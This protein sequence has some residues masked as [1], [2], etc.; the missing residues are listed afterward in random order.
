MKRIGALVLAVGVVAAACGGGG[1]GS[2]AKKLTL[3]THDSFAVSPE[4]LQ[5]FTD[6]TGI[7][8][9]VAKGQDA[10]VVLNQAILT[11][12]KPEGDVLWG[13]DNTLL[14]RAVSSGAFEP[15]ASPELSALDQKAVG[16]VPGHEL[17]PVD[18]G[19]VCVNV[20]KSWFAGKGID[21]P[22]RLDDLA[23]P[24]YKD[25]TVVENPNISSPGLAFMIATVG[26][27]GDIGWPAYWQALRANGVKVVDSWTQAYTVEF[28]GG[29]PTG[30]RPIVVSYGSSPP[31]EIVYA[32]DP[33]PA[34]P[35][36]TS[37][38]DG[39]FEQVEFA[40]VLAG[41]KRAAEAQQ[42]IDFLVQDKFQADMP[43]NMFVYPIRTGTALPD[44][45][46]KFAVV[47][48]APVD[49]APDYIAAHRD[50]WLQKW[51]GVVLG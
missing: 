4:V 37:F 48:D 28:T 44:V 8:V 2:S 40:G 43:L 24:K 34:E 15:Y 22:T 49:V 12:G 19:Y 17:T 51:Q 7:K 5:A 33:K 32:A 38:T 36:T 6:Q 29:S 9:D 26:Y 23:N 39:C 14:S 50:E 1:S 46:Q 18:K 13:V 42:L 45:F 35:K 10:A 31:A 11:K 30:T 41:T 3:I 25:L 21:V 20:D 47:P 27:F 16:L